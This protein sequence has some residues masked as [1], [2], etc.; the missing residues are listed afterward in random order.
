MTAWIALLTILLSGCGYAPPTPPEPN[1]ILSANAFFQKQQLFAQV[2]LNPLFIAKIKQQIQQGEPL[3]ATY[4]LNLI[5]KHPWLPDIRIL[6]RTIQR[7]MRLRLITQHYELLEGNNGLLHYATH[8]NEAL[9][10][11]GN[12]RF[13]LLHP[14]VQLLPGVRY[15]LETHVSI[16]HEGMSRLFQLLGRWITTD[17]PLDFVY[18]SELPTP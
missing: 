11:F 6:Q 12:P 1:A 17:Q 7:H 14:R 2:T 5:R 13:I 16:T 18:R 3:Q 10:F 4:T 9:Q 8:E 15:Q